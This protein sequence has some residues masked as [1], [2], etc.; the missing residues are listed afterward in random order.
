[1]LAQPGSQSSAPAGSLRRERMMRRPFP[2][3][4]DILGKVR[5]R[6]E[7]ILRQARLAIGT[8]RTAELKRSHN[9]VVL[10]KAR[11]VVAQA[12]ERQQA[13][14]RAKASALRALASVRA[15]YA[16]IS[17]S[18]SDV[19]REGWRE[20]QARVEAELMEIVRRA[21]T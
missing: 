21:S 17:S 20:R 13:R 19:D 18:T 16:N 5:P 14:R 4:S 15:A 7:A 12:R 11:E 3:P 10:S 6:H 2:L 9:A 8:A 1:M